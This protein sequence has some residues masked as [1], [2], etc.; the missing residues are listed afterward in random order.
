MANCKLWYL[1]QG[2]DT[3]ED[4]TLATQH[5]RDVGRVDVAAIQLALVYRQFTEEYLA[6]H[7]GDEGLGCIQRPSAYLLFSPW[8]LDLQLHLSLC[9]T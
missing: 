9:P 5:V 1:L 4:G 2:I 7:A 6:G 8:Q 3:R